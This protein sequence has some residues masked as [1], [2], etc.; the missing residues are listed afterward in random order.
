MQ[1]SKAF[2]ILLIGLLLAFFCF[3]QN[4]LVY[5]G[6]WY[7]YIVLPLLFVGIATI[8][9][10][11]LPSQLAVKKN[12]RELIEYVIITN[13]L[14]IVLYLLSGLIPGFGKNPLDTSF[15]GILLNIISNVPIYISL[16]IIRYKL[17]NNVYK[18]DKN[19]IFVLIVL[20][21]SIWDI[22]SRSIF[23]T[24]IS[25][26]KIYSLIFYSIIP[27]IIQNILFTYI[28][29][30]G[31]FVPNI[32]YRIAMGLFYWITPILPKLPEVF[33]AI[34]ST[35][36]PFFL[37]L[38]IRYFINS[39]DRNRAQTNIY[40]ENPRSLIPFTI[41]LIL[42]IWFALGAFPIKPFGVATNSM[43]PKYKV[44][45]VVITN[46]INAQKYK[47]GDVI[48][49]KIEDQTIIH[50][51]QRITKDKDGNFVFITKGDFNEDKDFNPVKEE[52]LI[53]KVIFKVKYAA[54]PSIWLHS[55]YSG[56]TEALVE[57]GKDIWKEELGKRR[58]I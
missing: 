29:L 50:R 39:R 21:F 46:E 24:N 45:D 2:T 54:L 11:L 55:V 41:V 6:K 17:V 22:N 28:A 31:D 44:G 15:S 34:L 37:I 47:E 30:K 1:K 3:C 38:Y 56:R 53:G 35:V 8:L 36:I 9:N 10:I 49:Y 32:V 5:L 57:T 33:D 58:I 12:R 19:I 26:Y 25:I 14:Y 42:A 40:E 18:Q 23:M 51:I 4:V 7:T 16:E 48:A 20:C 43:Y 52:Q 13:L 27:I